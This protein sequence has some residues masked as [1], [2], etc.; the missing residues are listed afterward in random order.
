MKKWGQGMVGGVEA[1]KYAIR[2]LPN[3]DQA[4]AR[5]RGR[6]AAVQA[7]GNLGVYPKRL[8]EKFATVYTFEPAADCFAALLK[9]APEP[10]II[11]IQAAVGYSRNLVGLS[12]IRRDGR[13]NHHEGITHVSGDG[14]IPTL[15][16]D[17]LG[18]PVC[19]LIALDVEGGELDALM[20]ACRTIHRCRPVLL[21]EVNKNLAYV[22]M[23]PERVRDFIL[24]FDYR[25]VARLASDDLFL[26]GE[27][28]T[29]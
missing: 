14:T 2:D 17:D 20:G 22:D 25:Y 21:V 27:W 23:T 18:L 26:P 9:N 7:G 11:K 8:A 5:A 19:D 3:L 6:T 4:I 13:P 24:G 28:G 15:R 10:N 29:A 1:L 12:R 16:I